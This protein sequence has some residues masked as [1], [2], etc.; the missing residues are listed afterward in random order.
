MSKILITGKGSFVGHNFINHSVYKEI[1][2]VSLFD[3]VP[4]KIKFSDY[5]VVLHLVAI[6]HQNISIPESDYYK[7]NCD[8]A[9][10]IANESK[11]AGVKQ[12]VFLST[13]KVYGKYR[14]ESGYWNEFSKCLPD[15]SYGKSKYAAELA[16]KKLEDEDFRVSIIRTPLIYGKGVKANMLG[17]IK[18]V[19]FSSVLPFKDIKNRRNFTAAENLVAFIDRIIER[20]ASG[21]FIAMD[22]NALSTSEMVII[23]SEFL[24]KKLYL[25]KIPDFLVKIG[26]KIFPMLFDRLYGSYE[27]DNSNTLNIL[28]FEP[29]LTTREGVR[30][31]I[32]SLDDRPLFN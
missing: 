29:P 9:V 28:E 21:V 5:K 12:F 7:I 6:V 22:K 20:K 32:E 8:L 2:E 27:M 13:V 17:L 15:D 10:E 1:D 24:G 11:K 23:I 30:R 16:L 14:K 25:F 4:G 31:M 26:F 3:Y 19:K 18:L